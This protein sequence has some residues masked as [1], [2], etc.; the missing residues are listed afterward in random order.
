MACTD[1]MTGIATRLRPA[2]ACLVPESRQEITTEG[3]LDILGDR[4]DKALAKAQL[5]DVDG[6][7]LEA[8]GG[9][10]LEQAVAQQVDRADL[11]VQRLADDLDDAVELGLRSRAR[12]HHIVK[13]L[14]DFACG[15]GG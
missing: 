12:R 2:A 3:G 8:A 14:E 6:L 7:L 4:A 10:E 5:G 13:T 9:I 15:G 11:A 1:E